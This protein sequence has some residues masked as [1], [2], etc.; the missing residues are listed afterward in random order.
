M[1]TIAQSYTDKQHRDSYL[2]AVQKFRL[3]YWDYY[4]PRD[5][6]V[7]FQG[8]VNPNGTTKFS[9]KFDMPQIFTLVEI[10][11][12]KAPT[13]VATPVKNPFQSYKFPDATI[14]SGDDHGVKAVAAYNNV[15]YRS[16]TT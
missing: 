9:Y 12:L 8:I 13:N 16:I 6:D 7:T 4:R 2:Q 5:Y 3:P 11:V 10:K 15:S 14:A 1:V